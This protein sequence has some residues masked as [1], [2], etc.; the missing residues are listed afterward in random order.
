MLPSF[1][2]IKHGNA[3]KHIPL[4]ENPY[5]PGAGHRPPF[6][7]GRNGEL[8]HFN[9]LLRQGFFSSNVLITG[10]RGV[11]KTVLLGE[12]RRMVERSG[13]IWVGN[14]LSE[15]SSLSED[16]IALRLLTDISDAFGRLLPSNNKP[17]LLKELDTAFEAGLDATT[18]NS[19]IYE[20]LKA[21]YERSPGLPSDRLKAVH[22]GTSIGTE[23]ECIQ[24]HKGNILCRHFAV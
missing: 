9:T 7:A 24:P 5:R 14:D 23:V 2:K 16:R 11:G 21:I 15:S 13:W 6:I 4:V 19:V 8:S 10:L 22:Q 17:S 20:A 18:N 3:V 1:K 12:M